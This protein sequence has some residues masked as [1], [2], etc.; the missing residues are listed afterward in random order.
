MSQAPGVSRSRPFGLIGALI[1]PV[2][3]AACA[4][5]AAA[6]PVPLKIGAIFPLSG[7]DAP[8]STD[9]Y[10]GVTLAEQ[11]VNAAGGIDGRS[12]TLDTRDVEDQSQIAGAVASLDAD[13]VP[14]VI[15]AYSSQLSIPAAAA[16]SADGMVYWETGAVADRVTGKGSPLVF[17][18]G[19][20]GA[21]LGLGAEVGISTQKLHA[22]G[23]MGLQALTSVKYVVYG[24]G[25]VRS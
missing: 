25:Q 19:V 13:G 3:A 24:E 2:L 6:G 12:I 4:T 7:S 21:E 11:M 5:V 14:V 22:R 18:V 15:G 1:L 17:R 16:V 8:D 20:D 10:L 9:E 23:P